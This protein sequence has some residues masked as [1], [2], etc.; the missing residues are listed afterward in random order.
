MTISL[1]TET[2]EDEPFLRRLIVETI[3]ASL[4]A[5]SWP[6]PMRTPLLEI[7]YSARRQSVRG[8]SP[9]GD[10]QLILVDGESAG[11]L[12]RA[13]LPDEIRLVEIM[14]ADAHRGKGVGTA[15]LSTVLSEAQEKSKPVRLSV[16]LRNSGA[17]RLY[18]RLGFRRVAGDELQHVMEKQT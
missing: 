18:E 10:S 15:V 5:S 11:W 17:F 4:G 2:P 12:Y 9:N 6:E 3:A 14:V 7:Q 1:R 16:D 13:E 8:N